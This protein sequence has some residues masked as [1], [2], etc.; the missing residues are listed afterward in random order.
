MVLLKNVELSKSEISR[1]LGKEKPTG[2]LNDM[3]R[4][5]LENGHVVYTIPEKPNSRLQK[6]RITDQG[7]VL[8]QEKEEGNE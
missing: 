6:Y 3:M 2:Y 5:L 1:A 4:K 7:K 8:I